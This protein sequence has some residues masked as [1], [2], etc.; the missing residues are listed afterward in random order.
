MAKTEKTAEITK[1]TSPSNQNNIPSLDNLFYKTG[2]YKR[3][4]EYK[5][6]LHFIRRFPYYSPYNAHLLYMQ[7][8]GCYYV[9]MASTW[10]KEFWRTVKLSANPLIILVP[11]GPVGYVFDIEDT[12]GEPFP[13]NL[14]NLFKTKGNIPDTLYFRL[15]NNLPRI[16][17]SFTEADFGSQM[18]GKIVPSKRTAKQIIHNRKQDIYVKI[19]YDIFVNKN[20]NKND[21]F[22]TIL[23][24]LAHLYCGHIDD[25]YTELFAKKRNLDKIEKEFEAGSV[26]WIICE[27]LGFYN[28]SEKYLAGY[29]KDYNTIPNIS[30]DCILNAAGKIEEMLKCAI[31]IKKEIILKD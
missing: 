20:H 5:D 28:P 23:H 9:A 22:P 24:E 29:M 12:E 31:K 8:P 7:K 6:L 17:I 21:T 14:I 4:A 10:E 3:S 25:E 11:F 26:A 30:L 13:E 18:A 15:I 1:K 19:F 27:R 2:R 16:G